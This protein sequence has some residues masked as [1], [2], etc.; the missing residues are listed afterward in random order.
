M[1]KV[2][3]RILKE[4]IEKFTDIGYT[5]L[6][7]DDLCRE[8]GIS[9]KTLYEH[10]PSKKELFQKCAECIF[11]EMR[12]ESNAVLE[13]MV[14]NNEFHFFEQLGNM[15]AVVNKHHKRLKP[16][17]IEDIKKYAH[18]VWD[19]RI[20]VEKEKREYFEKIWELGLKEGMIK[21]SI[22]KNI[23]YMMYFGILHSIMRPDILADLSISSTQALEQIYEI[24][25]SGILTDEGIKD[26][27]EKTK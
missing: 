25:M 1:I 21:P 11:D 16:K 10:F 19:C 13:K 14:E 6:N 2:E 18:S 17:F 20:E 7:L 5:A 22:N 26:F 3:E 23:Y 4:A 15:Y 12:T 24:L 27:K 8:L 9:K